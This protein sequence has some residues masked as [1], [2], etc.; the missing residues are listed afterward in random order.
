MKNKNNIIYIL[1][2]VIVALIVFYLLERNRYRN[3]IWECGS[4][5][6]MLLL[7]KSVRSGEDLIYY[8]LPKD[9][10][11]KMLPDPEN[12]YVIKLDSSIVIDNNWHERYF[13]ETY[14][15][16]RYDTIEVN[17]VRWRIPY[18]EIPNLYLG[19]TKRDSVWVVEYGVQWNDDTFID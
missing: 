14:L 10:V 2:S 3:M 1:L 19:L 5:Y 8:D 9:S 4:K 16:S 17:I 15:K 11:M 12:D 13:V 7:Y 6:S 18:H